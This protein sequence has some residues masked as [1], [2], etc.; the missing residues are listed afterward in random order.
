ALN[1]ADQ[2][3]RALALP[4]SAFS[5][6]RSHGTLDQEHTAHFADLVNRLDDD[7]DRAAVVHAANMF[8][9]LYGAIFRSLPRSSSQGQGA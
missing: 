8:Y 6:L 5:Y 3:Q 7:A 9:G 4:P 1:A 2:I